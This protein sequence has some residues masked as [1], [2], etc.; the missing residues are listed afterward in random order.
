MKKSRLRFWL[1]TLGGVALL[2]CIAVFLPLNLGTTHIRA[3]ADIPRSPHE[4]FLYVTTPTTW[5]RWHPSSIAVTGDAGHSLT[6]GESVREEFRVAGHH[7]FAV[8][9]VVALEPDRLWRIEGRID[10]HVAGTVTYTI[11]DVDGRAHFVRNFDYPSRTLLF[12][13][14][15]PFVIKPRVMAESKQAVFQ[16]REVLEAGTRVP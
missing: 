13:I 16:L 7:G 5:P 2:V 11:S 14:L 10:G 9:T 12:A 15:N 6:L 8:W 3:E 4:V 1:L